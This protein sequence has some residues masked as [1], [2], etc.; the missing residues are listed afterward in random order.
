M[1][2]PSQKPMGYVCGE[3]CEFTKMEMKVLSGETLGCKSALHLDAL[4]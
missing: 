2:S 1:R 3:E 4:G